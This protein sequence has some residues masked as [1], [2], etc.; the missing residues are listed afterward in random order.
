MFAEMI[1]ARIRNPKRRA[2]EM[3]NFQEI[4]DLVLIA[5]RALII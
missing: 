2:E 3:N 1:N 5:S 4:G